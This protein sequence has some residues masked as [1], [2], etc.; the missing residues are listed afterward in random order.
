MWYGSSM[1][2]VEARFLRLGRNKEVR[3]N[4]CMTEEKA[5]CSEENKGSG[6]VK[7]CFPVLLFSCH[8]G[9]FSG[10]QCSFSEIKTVIS[11]LQ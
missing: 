7:D 9:K 11:F 4:W 5:A 2:K 6:T 1:Q 10:P 8:L 3:E